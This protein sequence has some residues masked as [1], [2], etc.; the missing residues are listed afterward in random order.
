MKKQLDALIEFL[1]G[2]PVEE[3]FY[4]YYKKMYTDGI[5]RGCFNKNNRCTYRSCET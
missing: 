1:N 3:D 4:V 5:R 2:T